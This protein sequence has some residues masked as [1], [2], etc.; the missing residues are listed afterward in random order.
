MDKRA[1]GEVKM[2]Q[3]SKHFYQQESSD[4]SLKI[5]RCQFCDIKF[6]HR[7]TETMGLF[8]DKMHNFTQITFIW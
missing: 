5:A 6:G 3:L 2:C 4:E 1:I 8:D 7:I